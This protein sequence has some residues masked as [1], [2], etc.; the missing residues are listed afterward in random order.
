MS[1][2]EFH[3]LPS[4]L[5]STEA[6]PRHHYYSIWESS[7]VVSNH[8]W[9]IRALQGYSALVTLQRKIKIWLTKKRVFVLHPLLPCGSALLVTILQFLC[10]PHGCPHPTLLVSEASRGSLYVLSRDLIIPFCHDETLQ[11]LRFWPVPWHCHLTQRF[12]VPL[13]FS[14]TYNAILA[15]SAFLTPQRRSVTR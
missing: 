5:P 15:D 3:F 1:L 11:P 14:R 10:Q 6:N 7:Q 9:A 13:S 12:I 2:L 4:Y 8:T